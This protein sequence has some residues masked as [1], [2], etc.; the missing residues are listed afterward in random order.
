MLLC[1]SLARHV[2]LRDRQAALIVGDP[3]AIW[4]R[5]RTL[6][7]T[8]TEVGQLVLSLL[9]NLLNVSSRAIL[10]VTAGLSQAKV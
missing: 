6:Q 2:V 9:K 1:T 3:P 8:Q 7:H 4:L 5:L 10:S